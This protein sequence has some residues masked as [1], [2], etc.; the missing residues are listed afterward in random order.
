MR[1]KHIF[2]L[3]GGSRLRINLCSL[4]TTEELF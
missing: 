4:F 1:D 2:W 3:G